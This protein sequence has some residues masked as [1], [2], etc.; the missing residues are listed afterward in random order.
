[1]AL[2]FKKE[3]KKF[4]FFSLIF[5][6][7]SFAQSCAGVLFSRTH[8]HTRSLIHFCTCSHS[9]FNVFHFSFTNNHQFCF[10][11]S[12]CSVGFCLSPMREKN[13][14]IMNDFMLFISSPSCSS[15]L[16]IVNLYFTNLIVQ[17]KRKKNYPR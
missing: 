9:K 1:M 7:F 5:V 4:L 10:L 13:K 11:L 16:I 2:V 12:S 6:F 8:T 3:N 17:K 14:K 15:L